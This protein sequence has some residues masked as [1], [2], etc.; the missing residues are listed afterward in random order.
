MVAAEE[1]PESFFAAA[2]PL[3]DADA[4]AAR[5]GEFIARNSSAAG[6]GGGGRR[7]VC[8]TSGGTTVPLEQRCVRYIDN[9]S[10]GH[11]GAASTEYFLKAGYAVIFLH[12][13][14]SCQ[15][16]CRFLPDDS[17]L[18][19]FDVDAESKVQ[20]AECHA[21]VVKKAIGDYCK[22]IEGG[23]LL[24]LPFTTIFE[25]LQLL[26]MVATSISSAGPLGMFYLAAAV[27]DFYV[28]WDSMA[29]HKIQSGGGP[30]DMRLSQVP[31]MLSVLRNQWAPLAFCISFKLETD[32][33]ILI[34]KADMAL[35]KYKMNIVVANLLA[36]Y[37]EEVIIVTDKERSTIRKMNKDED[38]E[39]QIIK[40]LS[41]NHSKYI[42]GSTNGCVQSP[43]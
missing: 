2:P 21:P 42:C 27:S 38:L 17:F 41:Q 26:K 30:L 3:R 36:T 9:F 20:V 7:I 34:Q 28:P 40:I 16:Y 39:M 18:K 23:Y 24:K 8:V 33:D 14:G 10:S 15:P 4:V 12:R 31:K 43:Y 25:Y 6:A 5:L 32:S 1:N 19:F 37:K 35:N 13:R 22:A 29:K 11:R